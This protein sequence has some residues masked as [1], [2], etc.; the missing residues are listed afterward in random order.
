MFKR[1]LSLAVV[2]LFKVH[3]KI[4]LWNV[5]VLEKQLENVQFSCPKK[6]W[7]NF[8]KRITSRHDY[9]SFKYGCHSSCTTHDCYFV[10]CTCLW[11]LCWNNWGPSIWPWIE[12]T[13]CVWGKGKLVACTLLQTWQLTALQIELTPGTAGKGMAYTLHWLCFVFIPL[14]SNF[15]L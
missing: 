13:I 15:S 6:K 14:I 12:Y 7:G 4:Y 8:S 9:S 10:H 3:L 2:S 5:N 11:A 1:Y